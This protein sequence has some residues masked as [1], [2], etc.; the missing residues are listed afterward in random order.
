VTARGEARQGPEEAVVHL[1]GTVDYAPI[2][3]TLRAQMLFTPP[4]PPR[5]TSFGVARSYG[6]THIT[7]ATSLPACGRGGPDHLDATGWRTRDEYRMG[8]PRRPEVAPVPYRSST[9]PF[10]SQVQPASAL[11]STGQNWASH[12][13][14]SYRA[15]ISRH[16]RGSQDSHSS[17]PLS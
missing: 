6:A 12:D 3:P 1:A 13:A 10:P 9:S 14:R 15:V 8:Y 17:S 16:F 7:N 5:M 11:S 4:K 2:E